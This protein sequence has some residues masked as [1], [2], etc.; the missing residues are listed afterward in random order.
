MNWCYTIKK[1]RE[2]RGLSKTDIAERT[3]LSSGYMTKL[4]QGQIKSPT[5]K[6]LMAY[7]LKRTDGYPNLWLSEERNPLSLNGLKIC[8]RRLMAQAEVHSSKRGAHT[9]RHTFAIMFLRNGGDVFT[10][11]Q[12]LGH[13]TLEMTRKYVSSLGFQDI[14]RQ[15]RL[16]SP[17]DNLKA[18]QKKSPR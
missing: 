7:I 9:F 5:Q 6:S 14:Q 15:H 13:S 12:I 16:Y 2:D 3:R 10:L 8:V 18:N 4:E 11:Q 1:L 17:M